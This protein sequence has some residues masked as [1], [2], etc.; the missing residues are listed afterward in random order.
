MEAGRI[1]EHIKQTD[2]ENTVSEFE[3]HPGGHGFPFPG[4]E[5]GK[6]GERQESETQAPGATSSLPEPDVQE[7][8]T[9]REGHR[10]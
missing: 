8:I 10:E 7:Q 3:S 1:R 9:V 6:E 2:R 5:R 4:E